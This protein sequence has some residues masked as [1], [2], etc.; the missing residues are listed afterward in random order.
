MYYDDHLPPHFHAEYG[1]AVVRFG[2]T[3]LQFLDSG[4]APRAMRMVRE[5]AALHRDELLTNWEKARSAQELDK[6]DPLL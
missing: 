2:I 3:S 6:I 4:L 5:W 1:G